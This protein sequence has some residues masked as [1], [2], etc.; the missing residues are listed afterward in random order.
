MSF[1]FPRTLSVP[2][3]CDPVLPP[4][5]QEAPPFLGEFPEGWELA[6]HWVVLFAP[7][8]GVGVH[9]QRR[10]QGLTLQLGLP[11]PAPLL[12]SDQ[13]AGPQ[14]LGGTRKGD[15]QLRA[16]LEPFPAGGLEKAPADRLS[17]R[18]CSCCLATGG[19]LHWRL[20]GGVPG[21][22]SQGPRAFLHT[23]HLAP[24]VSCLLAGE[25]GSTA[26]SV[27]PRWGIQG[28]ACS[29]CSVSVCEVGKTER[30]Q[31]TEGIRRKWRH[32]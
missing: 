21:C 30:M 7:N 23:L 22:H 24:A 20:W 10:D 8:T 16:R 11:L 14:H 12:T 6:G 3:I 4:P 29:R 25:G 15:M 32:P 5:P 31:R 13:V 18:Q 1:A 27:C 28:P 17:S 19:H 26:A 2:F 9:L